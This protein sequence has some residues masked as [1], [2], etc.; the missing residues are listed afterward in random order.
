MVDRAG[1]D[2]I[3]LT[4]DFLAVSL[5]VRRTSI[6]EIA[7]KV[8]DS[9]AIRYSRGTITILSRRLLEKMSCEC[10]ETR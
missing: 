4:Q 5:G 8:Q 7:R 1:S 9:G 2:S 6:S 10:Y 3:Y